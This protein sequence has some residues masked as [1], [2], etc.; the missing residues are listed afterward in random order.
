MGKRGPK[1]KG[2]VKIEWSPDFAYAIGLIA[3]DGCL[4]PSGRHIIFVSKDEEQIQNYMKALRIKNAISFSRST[5]TGELT[6]RVQFGDVL[7]WGFLI[8]IGITPAKS[9]TI[10]ELKIPKKYFFDFLRG[11][12]DGDGSFHSYWDPRWRSSF[13]YYLIFGSASKE[14]LLWIQSTIRRLLGVSGHITGRGR[15]RTVYQLKY[16]KKEALKIIGKM[17]YSRAVTCLSRKRRKIEKALAEDKLDK[18]AR[19]L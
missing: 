13:M 9:K 8:G 18:V 5:F 12:H 7:F 2:K 4:S 15:E 14:H 1:P 19:V 10:G 17:Y 11:S 3:T 16:A 6:P